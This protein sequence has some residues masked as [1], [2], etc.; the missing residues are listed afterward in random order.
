[1]NDRISLNNIR[2]KIEE[3]TNQLDVYLDK[4]LRILDMREKIKLR[5]LPKGKKINEVMVSSS[6][7]TAEDKM[8]SCFADLESF[9]SRYKE[10][11]DQLEYHIITIQEDI[12]SLQRF[13]EKELK[14]LEKYDDVEKQV[15]HYREKKYSWS[16]I[17]MLIDQRIIACSLTTARRIWKKYI[18]KR[19]IY[20]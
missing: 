16:Q 11:L 12:K 1:M 7:N 10:T 4:K 20:E 5:V 9:D 3:L 15:I 18:E 8:L 17:Q 14:R 13:E 2:N 19:D 6:I